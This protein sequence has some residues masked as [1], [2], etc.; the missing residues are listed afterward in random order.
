[1]GKG[2]RSNRDINISTCDLNG[3]TGKWGKRSKYRRRW[4]IYTT[5]SMSESHKESYYRLHKIPII[6]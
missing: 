2:E 5:I 6:T 1:M 4:I 3:E